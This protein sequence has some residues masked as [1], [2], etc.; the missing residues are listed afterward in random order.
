ME[1]F[2]PALSLPLKGRERA[3]FFPFNEE[4]KRGGGSSRSIINMSSLLWTP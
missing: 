2:Y 1:Y 3:T 4:V